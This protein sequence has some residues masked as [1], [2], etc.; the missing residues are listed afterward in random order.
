[1]WIGAKKG[2]PCFSHIAIA[3]VRASSI[4]IRCSIT[5][6]IDDFESQS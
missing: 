4:V 1:M 5:H 6:L 2:H 3:I